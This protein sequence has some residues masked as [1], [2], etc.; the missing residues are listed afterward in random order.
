VLKKADKLLCPCYLRRP[1]TFSSPLSY[2]HSRPLRLVR[3]RRI[4]AA[5]TLTSSAHLTS[6]FWPAS[7]LLHGEVPLQLHTHWGISF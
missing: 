5:N 2:L 3:I 6:S 4:A 1:F 7:A